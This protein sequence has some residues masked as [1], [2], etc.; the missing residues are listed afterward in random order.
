MSYKSNYNLIKWGPDLVIK[1]KEGIAPKRSSLPAP[2]VQS[3]TMDAVM[4][5]GCGKVMDSKSAFRKK[6]KELGLVEF[7]DQKPTRA[8]PKKL[9]KEERKKDIAQAITQLGG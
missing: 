4:H 1:R 9:S 6:T 3:D 8:K 5:H 7:G 2:M